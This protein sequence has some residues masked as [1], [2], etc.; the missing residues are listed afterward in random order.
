MDK[1]NYLFYKH[2]MKVQSN[3]IHIQVRKHCH[4][5]WTETGVHTKGSSDISFVAQYCS[6]LAA[7]H[8]QRTFQYLSLIHI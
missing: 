4:A 5:V 6:R 7:L 8:D 1:Y 3:Y 2:L